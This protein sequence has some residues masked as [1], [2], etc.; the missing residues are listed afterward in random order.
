ME[1]DIRLTGGGDFALSS[2]FSQGCGGREGK[3]GFIGQCFGSDRIKA[4]FLFNLHRC[5]ADTIT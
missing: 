4:D 2:F 5:C 1:G 3:A